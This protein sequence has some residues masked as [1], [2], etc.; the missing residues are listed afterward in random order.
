V[1]VYVDQ[2]R[3][4]GGSKSFRWKESCHMY[5]DSLAELHGMALLIGMKREW[6]QERPRLPHYDLTPARRM[7][8]LKY[9]AVEHSAR[10]MVALMNSGKLVSGKLAGGSAAPAAVAAEVQGESSLDPQEA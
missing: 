7:L 2:V 6:F 9:G 1:S 5:A 3:A 10:Q 4:W 8:A